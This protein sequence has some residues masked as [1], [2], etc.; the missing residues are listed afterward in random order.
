VTSLPGLRGLAPG[1]VAG[2]GVAGLAADGGGFDPTSWGWSTIALLLVVAGSFVLG[3]RR[4]GR[5]EWMFLAALAALAGWVWL[6][7]LW[8]SDFSQAVLEGERMLLYLTGPAALLLLGRRSSVEGLLA[9]LAVAITAI[10]AYALA[11][12]TVAPGG[13]AYQVLSTDPQASFRLAGPL[14]YANALAIFAAMGIL[15]VLGFALRERTLTARALGSAGLVV[16]APTLYFTYGRGAW[17]ALVV[18]LV[19]LAALERN[20]LEAVARLFA[21]GIAPAVA[22]GL[23]SRAHAVTST[24]GSVAAARHDGRLLAVELVALAAVA[25]LLPLVLDRLTGKFAIGGSSRRALAVALVAAGV[26]VVVA[27]LV[28]VGGPRT[29]I[30]RAYHAFNAPAPLVRSNESQRLFSLSGSNRSEYWHVAWGEV[31]AHPWLGGGAG[32]YQRFWLRHRRNALPVLD[33]HSLY[34][35]TLAELGPIGLGLLLCA[36][37]VPLAVVRRARPHPLVGAAA[38][39]YVAFLLH[40]AIDWDWEMAAVTLA[41]VACGAAVLLAARGAEAPLGRASRVLAIALAG[42]L[43]A[44]A[45]GGYVGNQAA[46]SASDALDAEHLG[47]AASEAKRARWWQPWSPEPW[48]LLGEAELQAGRVGEARTSFR[49]GLLKDRRDWELWLDLALVTRGHERRAAIDHVATLNPLS[50]ELRVLRGST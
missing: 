43:C 49:R 26:A 45:I 3:V 23:A 14:G 10:C 34:L 20:R 5:L 39:A 4:P 6:S 31:E 21:F 13:G 33:A 28:H 44:V 2:L 32:S 47:T 36:L 41:A 9:A 15:L 48:R 30:R 11:W 40:A 50:P 46:A 18:G 37:V 22:V 16:L 8:S 35:E 29:A 19:V 42:L 24:P 1:L 38:G 27:A 7:L 25:G 17:P 12:R